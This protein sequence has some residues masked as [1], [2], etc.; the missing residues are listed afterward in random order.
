LQEEK[1]KTGLTVE[2]CAGSLKVGDKVIAERAQVAPETLEDGGLLLFVQQG[3]A[4]LLL[5]AR[6]Q[7]E[8]VLLRVDV[9]Q[10]DVPA[11]LRGEHRA[12]VGR[13]RW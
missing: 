11:A 10:A 1:I 6:I 8:V 5:K 3:R 4:I 7:Q 13:M 2:V 9:G 12:C